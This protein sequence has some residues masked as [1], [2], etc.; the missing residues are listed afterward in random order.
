MLVHLML[1][2][3]GCD[4]EILSDG[5]LLRRV[6]NEFPGRVDMEKVSP[7]HLYDIET[8]NPLDAGMSGFVVIAQSHISLHAWPEYGEVDIDICSCK[9]FSQQDAIAFA[10][11]MFQTDDVEAHFVVRG[12]RSLRPETPDPERVAAAL[13]A[14]R[15]RQ[16]TGVR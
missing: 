4:R 2:L 13:A 9:E 10:K 11:T 12:S 16:T 7:V 15:E 8:S 14:R 5:P 6:L 1:E 3:Y